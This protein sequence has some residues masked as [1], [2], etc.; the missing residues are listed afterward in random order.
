MAVYSDADAHAAHVAACDEA[1][2]IGGPRPQE[3][4]LRGEVILEAARRTGSDAIH[5]GYGF[6]SENAEFAAACARAGI[7]F[8]GP[9][10]AAIAAMG[11][12]SAAK[13]LDGARRR[14]A[15]AGL[16][17]RA[18]G[19]R[20][21]AR[22]GAAHRLSRAHQGRVGRRRQGH[23]ARRPPPEDFAAALASCRR[24]AAASF[25]DDRVL[26]EKYVEPARHIEVQVFGDTHGN[27]VYLFE[28]DC[29]VQR[30]HQKVI[31][32]APAPGMTPERRRQ[33]GEAAVAAARAVSY[34]GA[35]TVEFI[36]A[37]DGAFYFMEMNTRLQVEHPVTEMI[38]GLDLVEW[39]LRVAAGEPLP[40]QQS[41]LAIHGHAIEARIYAEDPAREFLPSI[42]TLVHLATPATSAGLRI[43]TGVRAGDEITPYY[44]PMIAKLIAHGGDARRSHRAPA[45][46]AG[47]VPG[48]R[49]A[50]QRRIPAP[51]HQLALI[52]GST[53]RHRADRARTRA[54]AAAGG[55]SARGPV[56]GGGACP[57]AGS[58]GAAL[59]LGCAQ[60]LAP[61]Q[62]CG[63]RHHPALRPVGNGG[64]PA[65][66]RRGPDV[67]I[68]GA[69]VP[70][71]AGAGGGAWRCAARILR[72]R[73]HAV[74][75]RPIP[76]YHRSRPRMR[77]AGSPRPCPAGCWLC[78]RSLA[79][80]SARGAP[81][82]IMEAMKMEHTITAP[83]D[84]TID[85]LLCSV[86]E[87]VKEGAELLVLTPAAK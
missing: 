51:P 49:R 14:A 25:N 10:P 67:E 50:H 7:V 18:P 86:G 28:R 57:G 30:R 71:A 13:T 32:E 33:M 35:G 82:L 45:R 4:Y 15:D 69:V 63:A 70:A 36:A 2:H 43:D 68:D 80:A 39:Q 55:C 59:T 73:A 52:Q 17:R 66:R 12:K 53:A 74:Q 56:G 60:W 87:Q 20:L 8:V 42:G 64:D 77:M 41:E 65:L 29:S 9:S 27:V 83:T 72:G 24:E 16:S 76:I 84:G 11:S 31:E 22:R 48:G 38:T 3:S 23:A 44:D 40:L 85:K 5:P 6:L 26:V 54:P 81:L 46:G 62:P 78:W 58:R 47:G 37:P 34:T 21:S 75:G 61:R 79:K 1:V 19:S